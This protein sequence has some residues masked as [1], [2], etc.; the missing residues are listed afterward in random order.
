M[1]ARLPK[2]THLVPSCSK[3]GGPQ[4]SGRTGV[5]G[6][7]SL[8][9]SCSRECVVMLRLFDPINESRN[10]RESKAAPAALRTGHRSQCAPSTYEQV[11]FIIEPPESVCPGKLDIAS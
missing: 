8:A 10:T 11:F 4:E 6:C 2:R 3:H 9:F 5:V 1:F 7:D